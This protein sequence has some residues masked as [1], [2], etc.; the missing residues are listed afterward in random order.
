[1]EGG[2]AST[3]KNFG[4]ILNA[5]SI[6]IRVPMY[7]RDYSWT[8]NQVDELW[9]DLMSTIEESRDHFM[10][11]IV[12]EE[13]EKSPNNWVLIDGQQ[14]IAS[15]T[16]ILAAMRDIATEIGDS[17][18]ADLINDDYICRTQIKDLSVSPAL[19]LNDHNNALF[20]EIIEKRDLLVDDKILYVNDQAKKSQSKSN[21]LLAANYSYFCEQIR[22]KMNTYT[23]KISLITNLTDCIS[24]RLK[25]ILI[26][27][28]SEQNA[29]LIFETLND[30]GLALSVADL[31][32]NYLIMKSGSESN[33]KEIV[34]VWKE[35]T[36]YVKNIDISK[37]IRHYWISKY[38][39]VREK[40]LYKAISNRIDRP[41][42]IKDFMNQLLTASWIYGSFEDYNSDLWSDYGKEF[43]E[44]LMLLDL[45]NLNQCYPVLLAAI[46]VLKTETAA[47]VSKML[48]IIS[49]RYSII[50]GYGTGN[51]EATFSRCARHIREK[52]P[53]GILD[54][55][56]QLKTI[57]PNNDEF[58]KNFSEKSI[59][60]EK[61]ARYILRSL[62]N[63]ISSD[64]EKKVDPNADNVNLEHILPKKPN[65]E[66]KKVFHNTEIESYIN[67]IGNMT[68]IDSSMNRKM[69]NSSFNIKSNNYY[70]KSTIEITRS[71]SEYSKWGFEEIEERQLELAKLAARVWSIE[72]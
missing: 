29:F 69:R 38:S 50:C 36:A 34:K 18:R 53:N 45:F 32:K 13:K 41:R 6:N 59:R 2:I 72:Y 23:E 21:A 55:F 47:K 15:I 52:K 10:G 61:Y 65:E 33:Q 1:M 14:R 44:Y 27:A 58:V 30:R 37:F 26:I 20:Q 56:N 24:N 22:I 8:I 16:L 9:N 46:D 35:M 40:D 43:K 7:Q 71:L 28:S 62:N 4:E 51:L 68:L 42:D 19:R 39:V 57:Y 64:T 49:F 70:K 31:L 3:L 63:F 17:K 66:W 60:P 5:K 25:I 11:S 12:V 54:I 48:F 67:R